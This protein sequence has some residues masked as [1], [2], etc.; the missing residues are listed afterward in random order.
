MQEVEERGKR[1]DEWI[2]LCFCC[3]VG[4]FDKRT[5]SSVTS[6]LPK[7]YTC[8]TEASFPLFFLP[9]AR[10]WGSDIAG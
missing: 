2:P 5:Q 3:I 4:K 10:S 9:V 1:G 6:S 8:S 7:R